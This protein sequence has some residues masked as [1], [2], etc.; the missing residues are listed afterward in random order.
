MPEKELPGYGDP[1]PWHDL[2]TI[3]IDLPD[4]IDVPD[5]ML[6]NLLNV[7]RQAVEEFA[8]AL[9]E[10]LIEAGKCPANYRLAHLMQTRNLWNSFEVDG[11]GAVGEDM[12]YAYRP[13]PLDWIVKQVLRPKR[14]IPVAL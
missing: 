11:G 9:S 5:E 13:M 14:S 1:V 3:R 7:A 2:E 8:P 4:M 10:E 12:G 6:N